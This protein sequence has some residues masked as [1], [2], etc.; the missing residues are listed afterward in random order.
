M[1][2]S[3][4][5]YGNAYRQRAQVSYVDALLVRDSVPVNLGPRDF[6]LLLLAPG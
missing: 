5:Y 4:L 3:R 1:G 6:Q 2:C